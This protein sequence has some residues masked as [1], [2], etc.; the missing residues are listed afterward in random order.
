MRQ[1][2]AAALGSHSEETFLILTDID[3]HATSL[4]KIPTLATSMTVTI[5]VTSCSCMCKMNTNI[6]STKKITS[7]QWVCHR[8]ASKLCVQRLL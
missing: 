8:V 7:H 4:V 3:Q 6:Y 1:S 5:S 2:I